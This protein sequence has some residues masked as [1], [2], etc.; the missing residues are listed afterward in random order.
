[1]TIILLTYD[2]SAAAWCRG[3]ERGK[4]LFMKG[5]MFAGVVTLTVG[6]ALILSGCGGSDSGDDG[7][8][9][10]GG[11]GNTSL[12]GQLPQT[13]T[14][15]PPNTGA[16]G[17]VNATGLTELNGGAAQTRTGSFNIADYIVSNVTVA[18]FS[19]IAGADNG[20]TFGRIAGADADDKATVRDDGVAVTLDP[21]PNTITATIKRLSGGTLYPHWAD[22]IV[23]AGKV[24][25]DF[26][27]VG[28]SCGTSPYSS[29]VP[30][31]CINNNWGTP[32]YNYTAAHFS[33]GSAS[34]IPAYEGPVPLAQLVLAPL[35]RG[36]LA[37]PYRVF[38][39]GGEGAS[40]TLT[41]QVIDAGAGGTNNVTLGS[42]KMQVTLTWDGPNAASIAQSDIDLHVV[43]PSG[44]HVFYGS[45]T[46]ATGNLD[47][48]DTNGYGPENY[49]LRGD[50]AAGTYAIYLDNWD[51]TPNVTALVRVKTLQSTRVFTVSWGSSFE[52][53]NIAT[54]VFDGS[55]NS[56]INDTT[57]TARLR[58][59]KAILPAK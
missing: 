13:G 52:D 9:G 36:T 43:E 5:K 35:Y 15:Q 19:D 45:R 20:G 2:P 42:G 12:G 40:V 59:D 54:V 30:S 32:V 31:F 4:G 46:G 37:R 7:G 57:G 22:F 6:L 26:R 39:G 44:S 28:L 11:G 17:T 16:D 25:T 8:G 33:F 49:Y 18:D 53:K 48:D 56:T 41:C 27:V 51:N 38:V 3:R 21:G 29:L 34:Q 1:M 55:G 23:P 14:T 24:A 47:R 58:D 50:P 10:G